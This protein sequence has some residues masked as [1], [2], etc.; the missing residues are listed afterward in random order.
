MDES[1][2]IIIGA[3]GQLG[4]A[5]RERYPKAQ[6]VD[7]DRLDIADMPA[8]QAFDWS[9]ISVILNAAAYTAVDLAETADGRVAAWRANGTGPRNLAAIAQ[10][11]NLTLVHISTDYVLDGMKDSHSEDEPLSPLNVYG[12]S[13]AAGDLAVGLIPKHYILRTSWVIGNGKNFVR[14]MLSLGQKGIAPTV[15]ADQ[16]GRPSFTTE[17]VA[18]IDHLLTKQAPF[19][20]YNATNGG[21][22]VSWADLTREIFRL[23]KLDLD[24]TD[25]TT[26]A[27]FASKPSVAP[28]PLKSIMNLNKLEKTGF[29]P[30]DWRETLA[31]YIAKELTS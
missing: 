2:I 29:T 16:V 3:N 14:T 8:V 5:L 26:E 22:P 23:A 31:S 24:V 6:A 25:T 15:V 9:S 7:A 4:T 17:L 1:S 11:H 21:D 10:E 27:Y 20:I 19:G 30:H 28:R 13:K 18:I 12:E